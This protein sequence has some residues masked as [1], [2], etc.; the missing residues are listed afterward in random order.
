MSENTLDLL[1]TVGLCFAIPALVILLAMEA[2]HW[3]RFGREH[4]PMPLR[5]RYFLIWV[6]F[7]GTLGLVAWEFKHNIV[8]WAEF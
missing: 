1:K 2:W 6:V 3:D 7:V 5:A 4:G 8:P